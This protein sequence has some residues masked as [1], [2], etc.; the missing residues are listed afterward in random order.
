[1]PPPQLPRVEELEFWSTGEK[2][3]REKYGSTHETVTIS[4]ELYQRVYTSR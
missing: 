2:I 1:M 4:T 3:G